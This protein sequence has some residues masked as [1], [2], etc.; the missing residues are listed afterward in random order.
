MTAADGRVAPSRLPF[1]RGREVPVSSALG[2][3]VFIVAVF[4]LAE[5]LRE[6]MIFGAWGAV[7]AVEVVVRNVGHWYRWLDLPDFRAAVLSGA[8]LGI[9]VLADQFG[10]SREVRWAIYAAV[11]L[12]GGWGPVLVGVR[13][14]RRRSI[15]AELLTVIAALCAAG[16]GKP[17]DGALLFV[18]FV[19]S[20]ALAALASRRT[21][22]SVRDLLSLTPEHIR[23]LG[24]DG[25]ELVPADAIAVADEFEV[26]PGERI[27]ADGEIVSGRSEVHQASI[28]GEPLP[29][30][31]GSGDEVFAGTVNGAGS[32]R[33]R[34][35]RPRPDSL[36]A[37]IVT[38]VREASATKSREQTRLEWLERRY[39]YALVVA[40]AAI[41][42]VPLGFGDETKPTLLR[43][44]A[45]MIV[46]SPCAFTLATMPALLAAIANA[47]RHG[48][49]VKNAETMDRLGR[50][51]TAVF[52]KTGSLT[53]G[54]P[55]V[56][57][58]LPLAELDGDAVLR[59]AAAAEQSS[60]HPIGAAIVAEAARRDLDLPEALEFGYVP[61]S[62]VEARVGA[63]RVSVGTPNGTA[64]DPD[65]QQR[66]VELG[67][68]GRTVVL[69]AVDGLPAGLIEL[70]DRLRPDA[71]E[72][73]AAVAAL[74]PDAPLLLTGDGPGAAGEIGSQVGINDIRAQ[75]LPEQKLAAVRDLQTERRSVAYVGDGVNDA[76]ALAAAGVG[77]AMAHGA[78]L[79]LE[80]ADVIVLR[81]E[82]AAIPAAIRLSRR[83]RQV[84]R[85]NLVLAGAVVLA[86]VT[87]DLVGTLPLPA[88]V[89]AHEGSTLLVALNGLRL[90]RSSAW[91]PGR[92]DPAVRTPWRQVTWRTALVAAATAGLVL[93]AVQSLRR[94][95]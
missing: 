55:H 24:P 18:I 41:I 16:V 1:P 29:V 57:S 76:P 58:V 60:E 32:L 44:M 61:G 34:V 43:A 9:G 21:Q 50:I 94:Y 39:S 7:Y 79:A 77:V 83:A 69:V 86:L 45:F 17:F 74:T 70:Q 62:G 23:K 8:L 75:L 71:A 2:A 73:V 80:T 63:R 14:L 31:K 19:S 85:E 56:T 13:G 5:P 35:T 27:G 59:F 78:D 26:R 3:L 84:M 37:R 49:L 40:T 91:R 10:A 95:E 68:E 65:V 90:L 28:T 20:R 87:L 42:A 30:P 53:I 64:V 52:D 82:L 92:A 51:T 22:D 6:V 66:A 33:V 36:L 47:S 67:R 89:G 11:Y 25:T 54:T 15:D 88:A 48:V 93:L 38:T 4:S 72:S 81:A 12:V 46:A